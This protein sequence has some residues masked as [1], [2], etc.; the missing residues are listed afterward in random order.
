MGKISRKK[1]KATHLE[2]AN[3]Y[4]LEIRDTVTAED[5]K[6]AMELFSHSKQLII[7]YLSG[8]GPNLD[9]AVKLLEF[10]RSKIQWREKLLA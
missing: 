4:L 5:R 9:T 10:F 8:K 3:A 7:V 2:R 1:Q 6:E